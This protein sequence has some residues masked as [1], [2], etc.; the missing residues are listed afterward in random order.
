MSSELKVGVIS[1]HV[2]GASGRGHVEDAVLPDVALRWVPAHLQGAGG[3]IGDLQILHSA[4][5]LCED[6]G[7]VHVQSGQSSR[8]FHWLQGCRLTEPFCEKLHVGTSIIF[9]CRSKKHAAS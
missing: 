9:I 6:N 8:R 2:L 4:Q 5:S 7:K 1:H 3:G